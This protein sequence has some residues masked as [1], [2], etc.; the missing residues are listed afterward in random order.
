MCHQTTGHRLSEQVSRDPEAT[1][2]NTQ[3][4]ELDILMFRSCSIRG[5]RANPGISV[6][7]LSPNQQNRDS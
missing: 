4:S 3:P 2:S 1:P 5:T 6:T 7:H